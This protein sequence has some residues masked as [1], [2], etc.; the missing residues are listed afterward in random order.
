MGHTD[1]IFM[2]K[3][4]LYNI[5]AAQLEQCHHPEEKSHEL[6]TRVAHLYTLHLTKNGNIP[7]QMIHDVLSDIEQEVI[8]MYRKKTYGFLSLQDYRNQTFKKV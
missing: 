3:D 6:I 5:F 8:E 1:I 7:F 4:A 2:N